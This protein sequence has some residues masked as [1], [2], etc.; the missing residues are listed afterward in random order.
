MSQVRILPAL[1]TGVFRRE[2][3]R[4]DHG[5]ASRL[6]RAREWSRVRPRPEI[7]RPWSI[8]PRKNLP[9]IK[10]RP[11]MSGAGKRTSTRKS[12]KGGKK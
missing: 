12:G 5:G 10:S 8:L 11:P 9:I 1:Q 3:S 6:R 4:D 2:A 7:S